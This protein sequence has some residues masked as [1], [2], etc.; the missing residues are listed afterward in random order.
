ME[1]SLVFGRR[2]LG[3]SHGFGLIGIGVWSHSLIYFFDT[4]SRQCVNKVEVV[5]T[6][7]A[8]VMTIEKNLKYTYK[9][10]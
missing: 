4:K 6:V 3:L 7:L 5:R 1:R 2:D 9:A 10:F 8:L